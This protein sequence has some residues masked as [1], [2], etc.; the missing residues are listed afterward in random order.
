[1]FVS[2]P[3]PWH[4]TLRWPFY[5]NWPSTR[6]HTQL[7]PI[8]DAKQFQKETDSV[9]RLLFCGDIMTANQ[10]IIPSLHPALCDLIRS[11]DYFIGNC[12]AVLGAH[13][14]N[15]NAKYRFIF[16]MPRAYLENIIQQ[17]GLPASQW[18]LTTANNHIGDIDKEALADNYALFKEMGV[19]ALGQYHKDQLPLHIIEKNGLRIGLSAWTEWMNRDIFSLNY[20]G[21]NR[22]QHVVTKQWRKIKSSLKLD[23]LFGLPHWEYEFQHFPRR[24]TRQLAKQLINDLGMDFIIGSHTH[25]LQPMERFT[26]GWCIY[27]LGNF[28]G[29]GRAWS[30]KL[31][32]VLEVKLQANQAHPLV[33]YRLHYFFQ[34]HVANKI[35]I[36]PLDLAPPKKKAKLLNLITKLYITHL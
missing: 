11:A 27:N 3:Y 9:I 19:Q 1:M 20:P 21:V 24:Q 5:F 6:N 14:L 28:A 17:T 30:V 33:S 13:Q 2:S 7:E 18:L 32:T 4:Y 22:Q 36:I 31:N 15:N 34:E 10:D 16:H 26:H 8:H 35:N 12:E 29:Q 25:T 23:Y